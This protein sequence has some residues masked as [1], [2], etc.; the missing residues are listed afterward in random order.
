[1]SILAYIS[2]IIVDSLVIVDNLPLTDESTITRGDCTLN[3]VRKII[4]VIWKVK[5]EGSHG[6]SLSSQD[7]ESVLVQY[8][9]VMK[10]KQPP[11]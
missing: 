3:K 8:S 1:M 7:K 9:I 5:S 6:K 2:L 4:V 10:N 11:L